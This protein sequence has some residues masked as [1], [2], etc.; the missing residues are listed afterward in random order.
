[1]I[2]FHLTFYVC[3]SKTITKL[4]YLLVSKVNYHNFVKI[5]CYMLSGRCYLE[6]RFFEN[7]HTFRQYVDV[8]SGWKNFLHYIMSF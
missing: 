3:R 2:K 8:A 5:N 1:M 6:V 7:M 4:L